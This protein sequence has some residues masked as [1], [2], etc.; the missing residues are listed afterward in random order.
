MKMLGLDR[1]IGWSRQACV[2]AD[3]SGVKLKASFRPEMRINDRSMD[4]L[5]IVHKLIAAAWV[6]ATIGLLVHGMSAMRSSRPFKP[7]L[8][9]SFLLIGVVTAMATVVIGV[10]YG[11]LTD[12][13]FVRNPWVAAKWA[14]TLT[15]ILAGAAAVWADAS[16]GTAV[17]C[18]AGQIVAFVAAIGIGVS[19]ERSRHGN[20]ADGR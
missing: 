16:A 19:L 17:V 18:M 9:S 7:D 6:V 3:H 14:L 11:T 20:D 2:P 12:Y 15:A 1:R 4:V 13:G 10:L 8:D 5:T